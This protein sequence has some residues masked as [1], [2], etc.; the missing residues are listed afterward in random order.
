MVKTLMSLDAGSD[1]LA[2]RK[3]AEA[4]KCFRSK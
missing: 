2:D 3:S 1:R 4:G